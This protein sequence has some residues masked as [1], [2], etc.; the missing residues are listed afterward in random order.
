MINKTLR[1]T[2]ALI[3]FFFYFFSSALSEVLSSELPQN[4]ASRPPDGWIYKSFTLLPEVSS[5]SAYDN[6]IYATR[7]DEVSDRFFIL[8][9]TLDIN[10][11]WSKHK[12]EL[13]SGAEL[14]RYDKNSTENSD[15]Y[16]LKMSGQYGVSEQNKI[17][18]G[19]SLS[20]E[21]EER[22]SI[23][24]VAGRE[25]TIYRS[26]AGHLG[27]EYTLGSIGFKFGGTLQQLDFDD[28]ASLTAII[29]NDDRDRH[30]YGLGIRAS[31]REGTGLFPF[32]QLIYDQRRYQEKYDDAGFQRDSH[33]Y[34]AAIGLKAEQGGLAS[35]FS[36]GTL[37][38]DYADTRFKT[39]S[40]LDIG[41]SV[42]WNPKA[43]TKVVATLERT[44]NETTVP[45][46][47][48]YIGTA[49]NLKL[50]QQ[51]SYK[52]AFS[53]Q[54]GL[55][56]DDFQGIERKEN[57]LVA[58][59]GFKYEL[60]RQ[61]SVSTDYR[62]SQRNSNISPLDEVDGNDFYRHQ[63][64]VTIEA[65]LHPVKPAPLA[66][67][68]KLLQAPDDSVSA[69]SGFYLGAG[70][71]Q[72]GLALVSSEDRD[73][74]SSFS[75]LGNQGGTM[76]GFAGYGIAVKRWFLALELEADS[77]ENSIVHQKNK[78]TG[79]TFSFARDSGYGTS[80][81]LGYTTANGALLYGRFG[82]V[83]SRLQVDYSLNDSPENALSEVRTLTGTRYGLGVEIPLTAQLY[84]RLE[85]TH[86]NYR[87]FSARSADF[88]DLLNPSETQVNLGFSWFSGA[89]IQPK[90]RLN[91]DDYR[92]F[93]VGMMAGYGA[94]N[95]ELAGT[96]QDG[97]TNPGTYAY[98]SS[99]GNHGF[100][101]GLFAG[102]GFLLNRIYLG[103]ELTAL[104]GNSEWQRDRVTSGSGRSFAVEK[105]ESYDL[106]VRIGYLFDNGT[107]SYLRAGL[108]NSKFNTEY[109]KGNVPANHVDRNDDLSG[110]RVGF[111]VELPMTRS[112]FVRI[113][114]SYTDYEKLRLRTDHDSA[115]DITFA[116]KDNT[117]WLGIGF[118]F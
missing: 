45:D 23:D 36:V 104:V 115:D 48:G 106:S 58:G 6:N 20:Q 25:P 64:F 54:A 79:R 66:G 84:G 88:D 105:K 92:G 107:L 11:A 69:P 100:S 22:G 83:Q 116:T 118:R 71:G 27:A 3:T 82:L 42:T 111:G 5:I 95:S 28:D 70:I 51:L 72:T 85:L 34:R 26:Y 53:G 110:P 91:V 43:G 80:S 97:G 76:T 87:S 46:A 32:A 55:T 65:K 63:L 39:V 49:G 19:F 2:L 99:F 57:Y 94:L 37:W 7:D 61:L 109:V 98:N 40:G 78:P 117:L 52:L 73:D 17:F 35:E 60:T 38:Q 102:Y 24:D 14:T 16:W 56:R 44:V 18:A 108:V 96:Q 67:F 50:I 103:T 81:R 86:T 68:M 90:V 30:L 29:N 12:I 112:S 13:S 47:S 77:S 8:V 1:L 89:Q 74:G 114:Y 15:D 101:S 21:H 75:E 41:A 9:P 59:C 10:A 113:E 4:T 33:G 93:Y 31:Y 62:Y